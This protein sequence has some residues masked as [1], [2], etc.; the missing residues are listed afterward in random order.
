MLGSQDIPDMTST[1][2]QHLSRRWHA[3]PRCPFRFGDAQPPQVQEAS[4]PLST[5]ALLRACTVSINTRMYSL[6][7]DYSTV[8][9]ALRLPYAVFF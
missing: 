2:L 1:A 5:F 8:C 7:E 9:I 6:S 3:G 4:E